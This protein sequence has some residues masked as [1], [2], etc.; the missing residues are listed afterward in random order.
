MRRDLVSNLIDSVHGVSVIYRLTAIV[1]TIWFI[2]GLILSA[3]SLEINQIL[4][5]RF[6]HFVLRFDS[7]WDSLIS[8][9]VDSL[10]IGRIHIN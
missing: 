5:I 2:L 7:E 9:G 3:N 8:S 4:L 6:I 1:V 10:E